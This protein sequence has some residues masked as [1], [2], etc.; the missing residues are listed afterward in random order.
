MTKIS[1]VDIGKCVVFQIVKSDGSYRFV[2]APNEDWD[3]YI[4]VAPGEDI[5]TSCRV[6][7]LFFNSLEVEVLVRS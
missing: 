2:I 7:D 1:T 6:S 5:E 3:G 4:K